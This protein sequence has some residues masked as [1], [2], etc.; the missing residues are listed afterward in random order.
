MPPPPPVPDV[1]HL[2]E[3]ERDLQQQMEVLLSKES[4]NAD[5]EC[6]LSL[7][8]EE[9]RRVIEERTQAEAAFLRSLQE[10][11][12]AQARQP[13]DN[14]LPG[15]PSDS[16]SHVQQ[17]RDE[18][19][20]L[21]QRLS[22]LRQEHQLQAPALPASLKSA[23]SPSAS[24]SSSSSSSSAVSFSSSSSS[25]SSSALASSS[26]NSAAAAAPAAPLARPSHEL[27][28]LSD[29]V[30]DDDDDDM[31]ALNVH[32]DV[33]ARAHRGPPIFGVRSIASLGAANAQGGRP[34][35]LPSRSQGFV[36]SLSL[37][38]SLFGSFFSLLRALHIKSIR[39]CFAKFFVAFFLLFFL[40]FFCIVNHVLSQIF[41]SAFF[42]SS[43]L[44]L[45]WSCLSSFFALS[46]LSCRF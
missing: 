33:P 30:D 17:V 9:Q 10:Q 7:L 28:D 23:P 34:A 11:E 39:C 41:S 32:M 42:S 46:S 22:V 12:R 2:F 27:I 40:S 38:L 4:M 21:E 29:D 45:V 8:I 43:P 5:E 44:S 1:A 18:K 13:S 31:D 37:S 19:R 6:M 16:T 35:E 24:S 3:S 15:R 14:Q 26:L 20:A 25:S 36:L